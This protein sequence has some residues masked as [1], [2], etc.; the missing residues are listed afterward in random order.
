MG[1]AKGTR[2]GQY[3]VLELIGKGG[4]GEVYKAHDTRLDRIVALKALRAHLAD[5]LEVKESFEREARTVA[6]L[7]REHICV[8]YDIRKEMPKSAVRLA[9]SE[10]P[11]AAGA[12]KSGFNGPTKVALCIFPT[13]TPSRSSSCDILCGSL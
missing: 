13:T 12:K 7:Q 3:E 9:P 4:M 1:L 6:S 11:A 5:R 10:Q 8:I 2:L